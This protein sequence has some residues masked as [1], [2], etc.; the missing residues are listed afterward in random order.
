MMFLESVFPYVAKGSVQMWLRALR[1][2]DYCRL[3]RYVLSYSV[4]S[5]CLWPMDCSLPGPSVHRIFQARILECIAISSSRRSS[6]PRDPTR[7]SCS[8]CI[9]FF[10]AEP[11]GMAMCVCVCVCVCIIY[12]YLVSIGTIYRRK[13]QIHKELSSSRP[14]SFHPT[15]FLLHQNLKKKRRMFPKSRIS[16]KTLANSTSVQWQEVYNI[17]ST[18]K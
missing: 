1:W 18:K 6:Q 5:D 10:I 15:S 8:S 7:V 17:Q 12:V 4:V 13:T 16:S 9:G 11:P 14:C 3:S 2:G